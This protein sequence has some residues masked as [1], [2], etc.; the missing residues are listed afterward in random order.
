[1]D[2]ERVRIETD[3]GVA[4]VRMV[5]ADKHNGLDWRMFTALN[6]AID[7]LG[8]VD[9]LRAVVLTGE[10]PSFCAGLDIASF[11]AGDGELTGAGLE[12]AAGEIANRA[13]RVAYGWRQL[14][15][16]VIAALRGAC[17]GGGLQIALAADLRLAAAD[18]RLSVMEIEYGLIPDMSISQTLPRLVR[19]DFARELVYSGRIVE[20]TEAL[21]LGLITRIEADAQAAAIALAAGIAERSPQAIRSAKRLLNESAELG[22]AEALAL[23]TELQRGLLGS[24]QMRQLS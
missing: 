8:G 21:E 6:E 11:A 5:R 19:D 20:A 13:Q 9:D 18:T 1:M 4:V 10:G 24:G 2:A 16:P 14:A 23:E 7:S 15:V 12:R 17:F 3:A 22:A